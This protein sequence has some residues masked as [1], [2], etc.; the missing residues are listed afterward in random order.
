[1]YIEPY[2]K[3]RAISLHDDALTHDPDQNTK[4]KLEHFHGISPRRFREIFEK[5]KRKDKQN[6]ATEWY[7]TTPKPMI[8]ERYST[9]V[10]LE[11][12]FLKIFY[13]AINEV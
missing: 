7:E 13:D 3:S 12:A 9:H 1:V 6:N 10:L 11:P 2:P 5:G 4:V 8:G